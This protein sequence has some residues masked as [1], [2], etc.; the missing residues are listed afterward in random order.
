GLGFLRAPGLF[1]RTVCRR[2]R[3]EFLPRLL[4]HASHETLPAYF[5]PCAGRDRLSPEHFSRLGDLH[6]GHSGPAFARSIRGPS[7]RRYRI[8]QPMEV[9]SVPLQ[10]VALSSSSAAHHHRLVLALLADRIRPQM[11]LA[12]N[13]TWCDRISNSRALDET[14]A[15]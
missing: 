9:R 1:T 5:A 7:R 6:H 3:R 12:G 8:A 14:M 2:P 11:G 4:P 10:D 13:R 15:F